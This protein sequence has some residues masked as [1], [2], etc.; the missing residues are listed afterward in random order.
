MRQAAF[1]ILSIAMSSC[2]V[3]HHV[4]IGDIDNTKG[5]RGKF[6]D[7]KVSETGI[8][9]KEAEQIAGAF[10]H[11]KDAENLGSIREMIAM[12]QMGPKTGNGVYNDKYGENIIKL[13]DDQC[14]SRKM[15]GL[16]AVR[17][18]RKY[19]VVSGEIIKV[20]G[21]CLK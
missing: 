11:E 13:I 18:T 8:N 12:F 10:L 5:N 15:T 20:T 21:Y 4:Q 17:E 6:V 19:P 7:I 9:L 2:A 14:P 3:L 16:M 1:L